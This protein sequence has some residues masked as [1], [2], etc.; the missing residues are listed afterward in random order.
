MNRALEFFLFVPTA[1]AVHAA[2]LSLPFEHPA[3]SGAGDGGQSQATIVVASREIAALITRWDLAPSVRQL[4]AIAKISGPAFNEAQ[5]KIHVTQRT[6]ALERSAPSALNPAAVF[7]EVALNAAVLNPPEPVV[8]SSVSAP[9]SEKNVTAANTQAE[10]QDVPFADSIASRASGSGALARQGQ[11]R[12]RAASGQQELAANWAGQIQAAIASAHRMPA[13][14]AK[15]RLSG[16]TVIRIEVAHDGRLNAARVIESSGSQLLDR[17]ALQTLR[18]VGRF[19]RAPQLLT[20]NSVTF[21]V[22]L[23]FQLK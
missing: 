15:R 11:D 8:E 10:K 16:R 13:N 7:L 4:E 23:V 2:A 19:P 20:H 3:G 17:A 1:A 21:N 12:Q 18:R 14:A 22:P 6:N 9:K 5:E